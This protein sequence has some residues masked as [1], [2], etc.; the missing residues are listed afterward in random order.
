MSKEALWHI[1]IDTPVGQQTGSLALS[2]NDTVCSGRLFS[3]AGELTLQNGTAHHNDLSWQLQLSRP[4]PMTIEC[5]AQITGNTI[6]GTATVAAF[7]D[8]TFT[9]TRGDG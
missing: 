2:L 9:G 4:I 8:I 1:T 7:G 3:E 5:R 6:Q